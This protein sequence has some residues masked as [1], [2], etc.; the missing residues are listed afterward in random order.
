M[1][2]LKGWR[3]DIVCS[4]ELQQMK[5]EQRVVP[6]LRN[7][8]SFVICFVIACDPSLKSSKFKLDQIITKILKLGQ[9]NRGLTHFFIIIF[10]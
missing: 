3:D 9:C 5:H 8:P 6:A 2:F 7:K 4:R 10:F 1:Q